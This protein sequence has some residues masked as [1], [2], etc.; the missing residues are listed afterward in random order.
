MKDEEK[1]KE[2]LIRELSDARQ[3]IAKLD[4][5]YQ[6]IL[7]SLGD[8]EKFLKDVL[9]S[10]QDGISI[11]DK[12]LKILHVNHIME[13]WYRHNMPLVGKKC[14]EAY[15]SRT[16]PCDICPTIRT[17]QT[18]K[19]DVE[20]VPFTAEKGTI[21]GWQ[22]LF[23]F[24][25]S[26]TKTGKLT[27][28]LEYVR[29]ITERKLAEQKL[30]EEKNRSE[31]I[32]AAIGDGISIQDTNL[33]ILYQN[34]IQKKMIG[35]HV[36]K[37][38]YMAYEKRGNPCEGCPVQMSIKDGQIHTIERSAPAEKGL[39]YVEVTSSPLKDSNG[40][41]I[42]GIEV[43]RDITERKKAEQS[44]RESEKKYRDLFENAVDPIFILDSELNYTDVNKK[45]VE[46]FVYSEEE[47]LK[48]KVFDVIPPEQIPKSADEFEKLKKRGS[49]EKFTGKMRT[50][51]N[52]WLDIEVSSS[53][54]IKDGEIIGSRDIVRDITD[55][56]K[57]Q[58]ELKEK[59]RELERFY[60]MAIGRELK[61]KQLKE[62]IE[63]LKAELSKY[64]EA[65]K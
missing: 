34:E 61:M 24:P 1:T 53:A 7:E 11:L 42:A 30:I 26:D 17:L 44:I 43:V 27:G 8:K 16:K 20:V 38:C 50:K 46:L 29:D 45:A 55:R 13:I 14:Y 39:M 23:T 60:D 36:G 28:V 54:I 9:N 15:H 51:D 62:E 18:G 40:K 33:K 63:G 31:A 2:Q 59:M 64:K 25:V 47:F 32:I 6:P 52:R 4:L 48:M 49:Y 12:D 5:K 19:Q 3:L 10:I 37:Y 35:D 22:E 65:E 58:E 57:M 21:K 41:I 56:V